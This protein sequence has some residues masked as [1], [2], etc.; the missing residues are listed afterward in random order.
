MRLFGDEVHSCR[1]VPTGREF[2]DLLLAEHGGVR[3]AIVLRT[4]Q[5]RKVIRSRSAKANH[6]HEYLPRCVSERDSVEEVVKQPKTKDGL[7][8]EPKAVRVGE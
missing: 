5:T 7:E 1:T 6:A 3:M 8:A 4:D 2:A